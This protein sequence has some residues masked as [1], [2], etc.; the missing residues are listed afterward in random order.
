MV[1]ELDDRLPYSTIVLKYGTYA[2]DIPLAR[3]AYG[4]DR[5]AAYRLAASETKRM[6]EICQLLTAPRAEKLTCSVAMDTSWGKYEI[7]D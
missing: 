6:L 4:A 3:L 1:F 5:A 2:V 7:E